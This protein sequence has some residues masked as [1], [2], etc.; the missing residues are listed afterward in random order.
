MRGRYVCK[1]CACGIQKHDRTEGWW[2]VMPRGKPR[3][4]QHYCPACAPGLLVRSDEVQTEP[5]SM[6]GLRIVTV[7]DLRAILSALRTATRNSISARTT[8]G[9]RAAEQLAQL[10]GFE[11]LPKALQLREF[12]HIPEET[13]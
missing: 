13:P 2:I 3:L 6:H 1:Y 11:G 9:W 12:G 5:R 10:I 4:A 8:L 7:R